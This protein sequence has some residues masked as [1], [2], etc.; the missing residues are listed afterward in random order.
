MCLGV[1][2]R[3]RAVLGVCASRLGLHVCLW[4]GSS[5]GLGDQDAGLCGNYLPHPHPRHREKPLA[6]V[7]PCTP[8]PNLTPTPGPLCLCKIPAPHRT[9]SP[10]PVGRWEEKKKKKSVLGKGLGEE[11]RK[12]D[13]DKGPHSPTQ[14]QSP[15]SNRVFPP[16]LPQPLT[17]STPLTAAP[18]I[19]ASELQAGFYLSWETRHP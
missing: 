8:R 1:R 19:S 9:P 16:T 4:D 14:Q 13:P 10:A 12:C 2:A 15:S 18:A 7:P 3:S 5:S 11:R 6:S 17:P